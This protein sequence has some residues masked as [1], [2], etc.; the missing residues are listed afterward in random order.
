MAHKFPDKRESR[1]YPKNDDPLLGLRGAKPGD[2]LIIKPCSELPEAAPPAEVD[3]TTE[4]SVVEPEIAQPNSILV[5]VSVGA[6][7]SGYTSNMVSGRLTAAESETLARIRSAIQGK[8]VLEGGRKAES[9]L[10][11]LRYLLHATR[12]AIEEQ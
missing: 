9:T 6:L 1:L 7:P 3:A 2:K 11:A 12:T 4:S 5:E 8:P 10:D